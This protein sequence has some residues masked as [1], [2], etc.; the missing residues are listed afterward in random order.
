MTTLTLPR[1]KVNSSENYQT[2]SIGIVIVDMQDEFLS[3]VRESDVEALVGNQERLLQI[4]S[5]HDY[6]VAIVQTPGYGLLNERVRNASRGVLRTKYVEKQS[7][8]GFNG[9][10]L[11]SH[12][13]D[14]NSK[15]FIPSG[16]NSTKC[17]YDTVQDGIM[18]GFDVI[19]SPL[20]MAAENEEMKYVPARNTAYGFYTDWHPKAETVYKILER[21]PKLFS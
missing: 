20:L 8:S 19:A 4:A 3:N 14:W 6:P 11:E 9:T 16:V 12:L 5:D 17:V 13:V 1:H 10:D 7:H 18:R 2:G 15:V 21:K